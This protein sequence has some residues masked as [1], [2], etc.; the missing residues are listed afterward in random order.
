MSH[1]DIPACDDTQSVEQ[2]PPALRRLKSEKGAESIRRCTHSDGTV[3]FRIGFANGS[4]GGL[5]KTDLPN[6]VLIQQV[7]CDHQGWWV[8]T[9]FHEPSEFYEEPE[10]SDE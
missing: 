4:L 1:P 9:S 6:D 7:K 8:W 10:V 5:A 3:S 2:I